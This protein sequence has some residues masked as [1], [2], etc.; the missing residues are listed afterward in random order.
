M[1]SASDDDAGSADRRCWS[2]T[3]GVASELVGDPA[4]RRQDDDDDRLL[5]DA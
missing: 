4:Y 2:R 5:L 3:T 1:R